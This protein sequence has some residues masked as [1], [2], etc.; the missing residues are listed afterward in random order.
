MA[1]LVAGMILLASGCGRA[2]D[3]HTTADPWAVLVGPVADP[4][5]ARPLAG[6]SVAGEVY[7][8]VP[9][10]D[11]LVRVS[12]RLDGEALDA[13]GVAPS[14][15]SFDRDL[16]R[17][18]MTERPWDTRTLGDGP[19][20][21]EAAVTFR[22]AGGVETR[23]QRAPFHV[24][25]PSTAVGDLLFGAWTA[26]GPWEGTESTYDRLE[27]VIDYRLDIVHWYMS[28]STGWSAS[29]VE[30]ASQGGR[31]AMITW[32]AYGPSLQE[33]AS[34]DHDARLREW[35]AGASA[36]GRPLYLRPF[37][38][39]NAYFFPWGMDP[40]TFIA[41]WRHIVDTFRDVG[42]DNVRWVW[43]P[44]ATDDPP[45]PDNRMELYY[46]GEAYVDVLALDGYNWGTCRSWSRWQSLDEVMGDAYDRVT[47]LGPQPVWFAEF[48]S[49]EVGG[50]KGQWIRDA[51]ATD[52]FPRLQAMVYF[53]EDKDA[54][55]DWR[56]QSSPASLQGFVE[57]LDALESTRP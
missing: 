50:D 35:A 44:N 16:D 40:D 51:L 6:V 54:G 57:A 5:A 14:G 9:V 17:S 11:D 26:G 13:A 34:G 4:A 27:R 25:N 36:Y 52:A 18:D 21:L 53:D 30:S 24:H 3:P 43:S 31:L 45:G 23:V 7:V 46:P 2:G 37:Q 19:H 56:V 29:L 47:A 41:A 48:G 32:E 20:E 49:T 42:A 15:V 12:M 10:R 38:E 8:F 55:C 28:F 39:M 22:V 33:I 1:W